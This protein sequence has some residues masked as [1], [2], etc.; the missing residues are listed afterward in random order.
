MGGVFVS[1]LTGVVGLGLLV[2][3]VVGLGLVVKGVVG[4]MGFV[5]KRVVGVVTG[6]VVKGVVGVMG[7]VVKGVVGVMGLVVKGVVGVMGLVV[8]GVVGVVFLL[9]CLLSFSFSSSS[10]SS[11][12]FKEDFEVSGRTFSSTTKDLGEGSLGCGPAPKRC[13]IR[14]CSLRSGVKF[15]S[16]IDDIFVV[17]V[18]WTSRCEMLEGNTTLIKVPGGQR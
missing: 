18:Y 10:S 15:P 16:T 1:V 4:V 12:N 3:G 11:F 13:R 8:K 5:V 17:E 2:K 7:L 14:S 9:S 6:I